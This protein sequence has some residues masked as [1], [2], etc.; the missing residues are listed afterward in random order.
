M[1]MRPAIAGRLPKIAFR[2]FRVVCAVYV[3]KL[4]QRHPE[5][6]HRL[7]R[8]NRYLHVNDRLG[9][10]AWDR[11]RSYVVDAH[12]DVAERLAQ[13]GAQLGEDGRP[14][15]LVLDDLYRICHPSM[16][17]GRR[18]TGESAAR[19]DHVWPSSRERTTYTT[20]RPTKPEF[21]PAELYEL[22]LGTTVAGS[23]ALNVA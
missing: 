18:P 3:S 8:P 20:A 13:A 10:Q 5:R 17:S 16:I 22:M 14:R 21:A 19:S 11:R 7:E 4:L 12:R 2:S 23:A 1:D 9:G 15:G 6:I